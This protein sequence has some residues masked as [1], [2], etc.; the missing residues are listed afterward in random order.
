MVAAAIQTDPAF[1]VTA[2]DTLF[3]SRQYYSHPVHPAYDVS[4]DGER[5]L[6][7]RRNA[8]D[9]RELIVVKNFAEELQ[10]LLPR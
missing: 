8:S 3:S 7:I 5:F 2:L 4:R 10:R 9:V 1:A 6:M